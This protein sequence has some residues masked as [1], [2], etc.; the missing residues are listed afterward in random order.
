MCSGRFF[1]KDEEVWVL[2]MKA[3]KNGGRERKTLD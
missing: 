1:L 2:V 3:P